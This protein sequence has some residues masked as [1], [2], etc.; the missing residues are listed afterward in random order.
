MKNND[1]KKRSV[2]CKAPQDKCS[3]LVHCKVTPKESLEISIT[4]KKCGLS[5]SSFLRAR[6]LGYEPVARLTEVERSLITKLSQ[7]RADIANFTNAINGLTS[8]EKIKLFHNRMLMEK[9][10][11]EVV[12]IADAVSEFIREVR[13]MKML[14][15]RT[16]NDDK[17]EDTL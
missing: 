9:W 8:E 12:P 1:N 10:Y 7:C 6:A 13:N 3:E 2:R 5:V 11:N 4:A 17:K 14:R 15:P 16:T